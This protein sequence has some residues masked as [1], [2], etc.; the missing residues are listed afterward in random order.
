[1]AIGALNA[2]KTVTAELTTSDVVHYTAPTGYSGIVLMAQITNVTGSTANVTF[3]LDSGT[4]NTEILKDFDIPAN[5][6]AS[7]TVGKLI[8]ETGKS[9]RAYAGANN[10]LKMTLSILESANE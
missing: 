3:I 10:Q 6:A 1:M 4:A 5:D 2:F 9:I 8:V 7:A